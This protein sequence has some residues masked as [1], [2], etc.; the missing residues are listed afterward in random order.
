MKLYAIS[1]IHLDYP[2]N[3]EALAAL[4]RFPEDWLIV[5][6]D[7]GH[8]NDLF[9]L[10]FEELGK[11]FA[12]LIWV[13]GNHDLWSVPI[14]G[15]EPTRGEARYLELVELCREYN[16][17]TPED[18]YVAWPDAGSR[19]IL[20]PLFLLYDYSFRPED[21]TFEGALD[22]AKAS[23]VLCADEHYLSPA[24]F[25]SRQAWCAARCELSL[26]RIQ[27][28]L[29]DAPDDARLVLINHWPLV[30]QLART[31]AVPR[32][33]LWCGTTR[34]NTWHQD[35]P[36]DA[37]VYGHLHIR[38]SIQLDGVR[39]EEVSFGY[40]RHWNPARGMASYLRTILPA[41]S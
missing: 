20:V 34:T 38:R 9:R 5:A 7:V 4:P 39:F 28:R 17:L 21:V 1:D 19:H 3:R 36:V 6:G 10:A 37:V 15:E 11:R 2:K 29:A 40:P 31:P 13:P 25:A 18:P 32:F 16:V 14:D 24:P 22:W 41:E 12:R 33:S 26:E 30:Q 8:R 23:G 27:A 35:L